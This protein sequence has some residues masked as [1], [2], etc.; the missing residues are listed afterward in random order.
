VPVVHH[1]RQ[2][3]ILYLENNL[4]TEAFTSERIEMM[5][6]LSGTAAISLE[7]ARLYEEMKHEVARRTEAE[8][9]ARDALAELELLKNRLEAENVYLQEE[10]R[11]HHNFEEIVGSSPALLEVLGQVER[12]A[13]T[14]A[15]VL[16][17]GETGTGKE[18]FARAI[19]SRSSRRDRPLVKV[20]CGAIAPG[21]VESELFGHVKGAFTGALQ[22]RTGR[23]ELADRGTIFLDEVSE[24]PPETQVKLLRVL[25]EREFEPVGS[26]RTMRVDVRVIAASN[27]RLDEAVRAGRFRADLLYRLNVFPLQVP[28]LRERPG[29]IPLL[30]AFFLSGLAKRLGKPLEGVSRRTLERFTA[31]AWPGNVRELQNIVERSAIL[32]TGPLVEVPIDLLTPTAPA[33]SSSRSLEDLEREH[34]LG[35]LKGTAGVIEGPRGAAGVLGMH[36]NT[37]RSRMKKLGIGRS[38][39]A[40]P[41]SI[42]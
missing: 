6:V 15:S 4:A 26:S 3:G 42:R 35:V 7:T 39:L 32:A 40:I 11:T 18:L 8:Q 24:L 34:I 27:R 33:P 1:G 22:A 10:I 36:P 5:R 29:D 25:Q 21:L 38:Q 23:F 14:D 16:I 17:F 19:H 13:P 31:Y 41:P 9:A 28:P 37:L 12:V 30:V 2:G 20:N